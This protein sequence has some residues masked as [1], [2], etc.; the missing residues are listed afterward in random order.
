MLDKDYSED[1]IIASNQKI[2]EK[3]YW[4][5]KLAGELTRVTF[6]LDDEK[7]GVSGGSNALAGFEFSGDLYSKLLEIS[8][9]SDI[10]L[11]AI[12]VSAVSILL[13]KYTGKNDIIVGSTI[14]KQGLAGEFI[15][16]VLALRNF[17]GGNLSFKEILVSVNNTIMEA[18]EN[19]NYPLEV[20][21]SRLDGL[22]ARGKGFSLFDTAILL[23]NIHHKEYI[24]KLNVNMTITFNR[25]D[26]LIEG[27]IEYNAAIFYKTSIS[28]I[29]N[30]LEK[31]IREVLFKVNIKVA[32]IDILSDD[33]KRQILYD[34]NSTGAGYPGEKTIHGLFAE[35]V[36]KTPANMAVVSPLNLST[37][38]ESLESEENDRDFYPRLAACCF[39]RNSYIYCSDL[40]ISKSKNNFVI[41]KTNR[42]NCVV[43]NKNLWK[44]IAL[45]NG[46]R[47]VNTVYQALKEPG[48]KFIMYPIASKDLLEIT[49]EFQEGARLFVIQRFEDLIPL[50]KLLYKNHLIE[51]VGIND[52][53]YN[54][55][56]GFFEDFV[57]DEPPG[58]GI[59]FADLI[60]R[61]KKISKTHVLLLGD[62][63]GMPSTG[64]L[65]LAAYLRRKGIKALCQFYDPTQDYRSL[66]ENLAGLLKET[67][68]GIVAVSMKWFLYIARALD[69]CEI[70]KEYSADIKVVVGGDTASYFAEEIIK[71]DC[72]DYLVCGDGEEPL[73]KICREIEPGKIPNCVYKKG[74]QIIKNPLSYIQDER[75]SRQIYLSHLDEILLSPYAS[76]F[77]TFFIYTHKGCAMNCCFCGGCNRA[78]QKTFN[79]KGVLRRGVEEVRKDIIEARRYTST[80][81]FD[82]AAPNENL[83]NYC[84]EIWE[85]IDLSAHFCVFSST[86]LPSPGLIE[87]V[88]KTFKY[89]YCDIDISTLSERHREQLFSSG[90]G[91]PQPSDKDILDFLEVCEK[92][93]NV[94]IRINLITGLPLFTL[95]D[96]E[97][98]EQLL[99]KIM[100]SYPSFSELHWA[101]L[102]AQPGAPIVE[103]ADRYDMYSYAKNFTDFF[104]YS[105]ENFDRQS[106]YASF[107]NLN[108]PYIYFKGDHLNSRLTGFY[109]ENSKKIERYKNNKRRGVVISNTLS[110][111]ELNEKANRLGKVLRAKGVRP[112]TIVGLMLGSSIEIPI[113]ILAVLK[114][115]GTYLPIDPNYPAGRIQYMLKDSN[116]HVLLTSSF[117]T[118]RVE[119]DGETLNIEDRALYPQECCGVKDLPNINHPGDGIYMIYTSGTTGKPKGALLQHKNLVNYVYWFIK[120]VDLSGKDKTLLTS[121]FAFDLGYTSLYPSILNGAELHILQRETYL[122]AERLL[123]YIKQNGI[124][125]LKVTP[126]LFSTFVNNP[127]FTKE[128]CKSLRFAALGGEPIN[129]KD[130]ERAHSIC[131][132][133]QIMNHYGPTEAAVGSIATF[134]DFA[135]FETYK[136]HPAIGKPIYNTRAYILDKDLNPLP[137]GI[138]G[139]LGISG[140][141]LAKGY[142]NRVELTAEKFSE[143]PFAAGERVYKTGDLAR[144]LPDGNIEFVGRKDDQVKVRGYRIEPGEIESL[145]LK[146][147]K[148]KEALVL[149]KDAATEEGSVLN[150]NGDK[151][152]CA[153]VV[154]KEGKFQAGQGTGGR[155]KILS[156]KEIEKK[157]NFAMP[158]KDFPEHSEKDSSQSIIGWFEEQVRRNDNK[159]AVRCGDKS[160]TYGSLDKYANRLAQQILNKYD[161]RFKLTE[162]E[163]LRYARQMML[164]GWG[165]ASQEKLKGTTV[166]V[167]GAGG[168]GSATIMQLALAGFEKIKVCDFDEV[169]LSN[170][171][172]QFLHDEERLGMNKALSA[173]S[174]ISRINPNIEVIPYPQQLTSKNVF[175]MLGDSAVIFDM[176]DD[177]ADK[178]ILSAYAVVKQIPH[179]IIAMTD[180]NAY[181][182]V[183]HSPS[184]PCYYC[185]FDELKLKTIVSGMRNHVENYRK[186]PLP[187][188]STSLFISTGTAVNEA[189]K[190]LLGF[191]K[192]AYNKF[193]YFNQRG[194]TTDL[195]FTPGYKAMTHLFGDHF[196]RICRQQG[197][198]WDVGW[199]GK[200]LEELDIVKDPHCPMCG[201]RGE[202]KRRTMLTEMNRALFPVQ[203]NQA[204]SRPDQ[205]PR[206]IAL[207]LAN[208]TNMAVAIIA[209]L[210]AG[211]TYVL[212][213][214][215]APMERLCYVLEDSESRIILSS[216]GYLN[217]AEKLKDK[218]N[219][220]IAII[221]IN[222]L[223]EASK[224]GAEPNIEI[225]PHQAAYMLYPFWPEEGS[226]RIIESHKNVMDF[227]RGCT[228][229]LDGKP[230]HPLSNASAWSFK[231][232]RMDF[233]IALLTASHVYNFANNK[234]ESNPV[235]L[236]S[237]LREYLLEELPEYMIPA[238][239]VVMEKIPLTP[240]GKVDRK[241]LPHPEIKAGRGYIAPRNEV[242]EEL[243]NIWSE[244]LG[245]EKDIISM[246]ANFF[247]L[248]GHSL[249]AMIMSS[250]IQKKLNVELPLSGIFNSPTIR[251]L[252]GEITGI[253]KSEYVSIK[254]VEQ[255]E[256]YPLS[257]AQK[258]M[259]L[260]NQ[261]KSGDISDN[262]FEVLMVEGNPDTKR[263]EDIIKHLIKRH[264]AFRTSFEILEETPIQII[265]KDV[266]FEIEYYTVESMDQAADM[267]EEVSNKHIDCLIKDFVRPFHLDKASLLRV[268]LV[269]L[270]AQRFIL[271]YDMHHIITDDLSAAIF[272]R[273]FINL[274]RGMQLPP[275]K[276]QYKDFTSWQN[277]L[278]NSDP[279]K[280]Q[281]DYWLNVFSGKIPELNLLTDFTRPA[282]QSFSGDLLEFR[283]NR[284]LKMKIDQIQLESGATFYMVLLA[285][286]NI[287]LCKYT[288]QEDIVVGT[289]TAGR[290]HADLE[291]VIGMFVNTLAMRNYPEGEKTFLEF[292]K[293]LKANVL[294]AFE[295]QDYQFEELVKKI[296]IKPNPSRHPLFDTMFTAVLDAN[297][298]LEDSA[299]GTAGVNFIPY[300]YEEK[301]TQFDIIIHAFDLKDGIAFRSRYCTELF[302]R[303]TMENFF[304]DLERVATAG[305]NNKHI[306]LKDIKISHGFSDPSSSILKDAEGNFSF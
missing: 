281:E 252:A 31:L 123:D 262:T 273:E 284:D 187:V 1:L 138:P 135:E 147:D 267:A 253:K 59:L 86:E 257:S 10:R 107:D 5:D 221:N 139:E 48:L 151:Y 18:I 229:N 296:G 114:A 137:P 289:P 260:V 108:Y 60:R 192:P 109:L 15:N 133:L 72:I 214:P 140:F 231:A 212:L 242:E 300:E 180:I 166:F 179:I 13:Y 69:I 27:K 216:D 292:I 44:L 78:Q 286:Y 40:E 235:S 26:H 104:K 84:Q 290:Q 195:V 144:W 124:T 230:G 119:F 165:A 33:D 76:I 254:P 243:V 278:L 115:G 285:I 24:Q 189:L 304:S 283:F 169:E 112:G 201:K 182:A 233:F 159:M 196:R 101:R 190:I 51:L 299:G 198:D 162:R 193:F 247:E 194:P 83:L 297:V 164:H 288:G 206:T 106:R 22:S 41:S 2:K 268:G 100:N 132:N 172:R 174:T 141:C 7:T 12:L 88:G 46:R 134:V 220:N 94:E 142:L 176:F 163:R 19:R 207:L 276:I 79:R 9:N 248:N 111:R 63:P 171:N 197:F 226:T 204:E 45:F 8:N 236:A 199:R 30:C 266:D 170:L 178:F 116:S 75:D 155:E 238:H 191:D 181:A 118:G 55:G 91:K 20:L 202:E 244:V 97:P 89:V 302:T 49:H 295:N 42:H 287:L 246:D 110:Y 232:A 184:T 156:L 264:E 298:Y 208:D 245:I 277:Q 57:K 148:I 87:F 211:K 3:R 177:P 227:L 188:V 129:V 50:V 99:S 56:D 126:S 28:R 168:G 269:K 251:E 256:Y 203:I 23:E 274:Y 16:T 152:L 224:D 102:H 303:E 150:N 4:S 52:N 145:L 117:H 136:K 186:N 149:V 160:L 249:N 272:K 218:V 131:T 92:Y 279:V 35:Q 306:K 239:F 127:N 58:A 259:Y 73:L 271:M 17:V 237:E 275:L 96:L 225:A 305:A 293:E 62:T 294:K 98:G 95:E 25:K 223:D 70:V 61:G 240:N 43:V 47:N 121:S 146:H 205:K 250:R 183:F 263:F 291:N 38:F 228:D 143:N 125:Y 153:Y 215:L 103:D 53:G 241:A 105:R 158:V 282:F 6:P 113:G 77:G 66:K 270:S 175:E 85:G 301:I 130:I 222:S 213:N 210:K 200:F 167:A 71:F 122:L 219:R 54:R 217:L 11:Y 265:H 37:L 173:K 261:F 74:G 32:E 80:F 29:I 255:R 64:L 65:Y 128:K 21:A 34:F 258:R 93:Q 157:E 154:L 39:V 185:I 209:A 90:L 120:E 280:K 36:E 81:Q 14:F 161:D 68:P 67:Q 234:E 82:F